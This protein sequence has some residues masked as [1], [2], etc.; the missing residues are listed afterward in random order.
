MAL[1]AWPQALMQGKVRNFD[2][3]GS[4]VSLPEVLLSDDERTY[5]HLNLS[6]LDEVNDL[7]MTSLASGLPAKLASLSL[8]FDGCSKLT[9]AGVSALAE[10]LAVLPLRELKLD[11]GSCKELTDK[12]VQSLVSQLPQS[13]VD[14]NL[15]F[16]FCAKVTKVGMMSLSDSL[17]SGVTKLKLTFTG[18]QFNHVVESVTHLRRLCKG[19]SAS[20]LGSRLSSLT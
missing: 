15:S 13:I 16:A 8:S 14:I 4:T 19:G 11:F 7:E 10:R 1:A 20:S 12:G 5:V 17:P 3:E 18:T 9:D 6:C 2:F